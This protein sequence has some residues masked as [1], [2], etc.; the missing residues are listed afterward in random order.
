VIRETLLINNGMA[1]EN[2][3]TTDLTIGLILAVLVSLVIFGGI[4][5]IG[6][7]AGKLVPAM[8]IVYLL[9]VIY[10]LVMNYDSIL[11]CFALIFEDAFSAKAVLGGSLGAIIIAGVRRAAFSNEAGIGSAP[12]AHGAVKTNEP[13]RE[14]LV[15]MLGPAIDT[16]VI[17]TLTALAIL[18]T[19]V[20]QDENYQGVGMTL[21]AFEVA[22][23]GIG[24]YLLLFCVFIFAITTLFTY[25]YYGTKCLSYLVGAKWG[26]LFNY[27][28]VGLLVF[29]SVTS[30]AAIV[31]LIDGMYALMAIPTMISTL[32]LAPRVMKAARKY[33][34]EYKEEDKQ[35][36]NKEAV[37]ESP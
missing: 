6:S 19:G 28:Y 16:L 15:A 26:K 24:S 11:S 1:G 20:W 14:G 8:L 5:R 36:K 37:L 10:I 31:S 18:I 33:L 13:I 23:P 25:S 32:L 17:C 2:T 22:M 35:L 29:G 4:K 27:F 3:F 9:S 30:I 34:S 21:R 7:V 12:M